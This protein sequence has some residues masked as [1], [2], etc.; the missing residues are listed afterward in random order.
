MIN[1]SFIIILQIQGEHSGEVG[2]ATSYLLYA[3][4]SPIY[5]KWI[6]LLFEKIFAQS[7]NS[8]PGI[9]VSSE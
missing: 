6:D 2:S 1:Y 3:P 8:P 4:T 9:L 7:M 5:N